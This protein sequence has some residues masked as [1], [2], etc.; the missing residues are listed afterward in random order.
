MQRDAD[1]CL[2]GVAGQVSVGIESDA[3][4]HVG[5]NRQITRCVSKACVA[6]AAQ[7]TVELLD[8]AALALPSHPHPFFLVPLPIAVEQVEAAAALVR[9]AF[10]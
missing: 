3:V 7:E 1:Q 9:M 10:V 2:R 8:L 4:L 5:Q 6:G